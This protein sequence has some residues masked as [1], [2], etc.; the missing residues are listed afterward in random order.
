[1]VLVTSRSPPPKPRAKGRDR[2]H[3]EK[4][5]EGPEVCPQFGSSIGQERVG[6]APEAEQHKHTAPNQMTSLPRQNAAR[7]VERQQ[8]G[9]D[10]GC[11]QWVGSG[12]SAKGRDRTFAYGGCGDPCPPSDAS[13]SF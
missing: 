6:S 13:L 5:G 8:S 1:M 12:P 11:P 9:R 4:H 7:Y 3:S 10:A 2:E